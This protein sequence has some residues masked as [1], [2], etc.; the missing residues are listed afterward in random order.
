MVAMGLTLLLGGF[1]IWW[2][3]PDQRAAKV[4]MGLGGA[5]LL[6][7]LCCSKVLQ[8]E[9]VMVG[10]PVPDTTPVAQFRLTQQSWYGDLVRGSL[11][12]D[13]IEAIRATIRAESARIDLDTW[14][15]F[16][17][18]V[19]RNPRLGIREYAHMAQLHFEKEENRLFWGVVQRHTLCEVMAAD[20][21]YCLSYIDRQRQAE[22]VNYLGDLYRRAA[23]SSDRF[24]ARLEFVQDINGLY[25]T[26]V[27]DEIT[28][29]LWAHFRGGYSPE[30]PPTGQEYREE[31]EM[32]NQ[33]LHFQMSWNQSWKLQLQRWA[34]K[35]ALEW[36]ARLNDLE[37][38]QLAATYLAQWSQNMDPDDLWYITMD[39]GERC[40]GLNCGA[41]I[42]PLRSWGDSLPRHPD[43]RRNPTSYLWWCSHN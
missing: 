19:L 11:T 15:Y 3:R 31:L 26:V 16:A 36:A 39:L 20:W 37:L 33:L 18:R 2:L 27:T 8:R 21:V 7:G 9:A 25:G 34:C 14:I 40:R 32:L 12:D 4:T 35:F 10:G 22:L 24:S 6:T 5:A 29:V 1:T 13:Q 30:Q 17:G 43:P 42:A 28:T 41:G 23:A 38:S